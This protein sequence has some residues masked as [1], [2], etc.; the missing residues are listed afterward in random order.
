MYTRLVIC[1]PPGCPSYAANRTSAL[2]PEYRLRV[3]LPTQAAKCLEFEWQGAVLSVEHFLHSFNAF[4]RR[5][6]KR[7]Q[8]PEKCSPLHLES[9]AALCLQS[10]SATWIADNQ[11]PAVRTLA[12]N[13]CQH[14]VHQIG[15]LSDNP[16]GKM[17]CCQNEQPYI[18]L[19]HFQVIMIFK[20]LPASDHGIAGSLLVLAA[21]LAFAAAEMTVRDKILGCRLRHSK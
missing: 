10:I 14:S 4:S 3:Y 9:G 2:F 16:A 21:A 19:L 11:L 18:Y 20:F 7:E 13:E 5:V 8:F 17:R 15:G 6:T 1:I 12:C